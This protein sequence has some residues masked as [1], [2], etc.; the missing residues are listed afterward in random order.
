MA[1]ALT[2]E[3]VSVWKNRISRHGKSGLSVVEF[4]RQESVSAASFRYWKRKLHRMGHQAARKV[5]AKASQGKGSAEPVATFVQLPVPQRRGLSW[6]EIVA[7]DGTQIR[8]PHE[9]LDALHVTLAAL[10]G[11]DGRLRTGEGYHA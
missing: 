8:L 5:K 6:I 1:R 11:Q 2:Q 9:N 4:C 10:A 3:E 7:A